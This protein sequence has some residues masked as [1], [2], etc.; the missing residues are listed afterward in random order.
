[1]LTLAI[2]IHGCPETHSSKS[3]S[4]PVALI[5]RTLS[6]DSLELH[7]YTVYYWS[8]WAQTVHICHPRSTKDVGIFKKQQKSYSHTIDHQDLEPISD[9]ITCRATCMTR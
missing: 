7:G 6:C 3:Q 2:D 1:M 8:L 9:T 5:S 4:V